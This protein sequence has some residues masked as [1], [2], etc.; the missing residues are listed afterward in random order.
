MLNIGLWGYGPPRFED[1]V[2][3][4]RDLEHKLRELGGMKWLYAHTY[5]T[6]E[7]FWKL[8]DKEWYDGLRQKY[9]ATSLPSVYEK[10]KV[11][12]DRAK[13]LTSPS[14]GDTLLQTWPISG[15][16]G[17]KKAIES[18]TYMQARSSTWKNG[19]ETDRFVLDK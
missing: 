18:G 6:E 9:G 15:L 19:R 2:K 4:N 12:M 17:I 1:F 10:V 7:E 16:Y 13:G 5:Y 8:Y 3:A 11:N 14:L